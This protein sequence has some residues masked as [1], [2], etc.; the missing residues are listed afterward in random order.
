MPA[1]S[2]LGNS[3]TAACAAL[4]LPELLPADFFVQAPCKVAFPPA[5][6]Y[7]AV[8][9]A[10]L[11]QNGEAAP[12]VHRPTQPAHDPDFY[13][14]R[15]SQFPVEV[16]EL[17][18]PSASRAAA[19]AADIRSPPISASGNAFFNRS[20]SC[21]SKYFDRP[22]I[23]PVFAIK[24]RV[25]RNRNRSPR[26]SASEAKSNAAARNIPRA[27]FLAAVCSGVSVGV[28]IHSAT[29]ATTANN[30]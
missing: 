4:L 19:S 3:S 14:F 1:P 5:K 11:P 17:S 15:P 21:A 18:N 29:V 22:I 30:L 28:S 24:N 10:P 25:P 9:A 23:P 27:S 2:S 20:S 26:F 6:G 8:Q 7:Q 16:S 13:P 12:S